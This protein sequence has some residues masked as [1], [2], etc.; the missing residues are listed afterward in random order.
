MLMNKLNT[1]LSFIST[2]EIKYK[3]SIYIYKHLSSVLISFSFECE[4]L[5]FLYLKNSVKESIISYIKCTV[6]LVKLIF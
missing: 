5:Y 2:F 1:L 3:K 6:S 4:F